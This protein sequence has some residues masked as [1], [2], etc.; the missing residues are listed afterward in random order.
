M[1]S[2]VDAITTDLGQKY[3]SGKHLLICKLKSIKK[4]EQRIEAFKLW[5]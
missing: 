5:F 1:I 3:F 2:S 4:A